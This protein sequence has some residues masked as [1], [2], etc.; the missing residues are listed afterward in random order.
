MERRNSHLESGFEVLKASDDTKAE[1]FYVVRCSEANLGSKARPVWVPW[2]DIKELDFRR[3]EV[4]S[5]AMAKKGCLN[6]KLRDGLEITFGWDEV[7]SIRD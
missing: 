4:K 1:V 2:H 3:S 5:S 7:E 6:L